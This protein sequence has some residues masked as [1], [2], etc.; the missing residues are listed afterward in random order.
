[1][2]PTEDKSAKNPLVK[3]LHLSGWGGFGETGES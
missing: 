1:M 2:M 3:E